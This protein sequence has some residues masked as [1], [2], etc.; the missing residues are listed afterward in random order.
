MKEN[1]AK[2]LYDTVEV[3]VNFPDSKIR[4]TLGGYEV[5]CKVSEEWQRVTIDSLKGAGVNPLGKSAGLCAYETVG[6]AY[7]YEQAI[8]KANEMA[9]KG[10]GDYV[11]YIVLK[12]QVQAKLDAWGGFDLSTCVSTSLTLP[13]GHNVSVVLGESI[14]TKKVPAPVATFLKLGIRGERSYRWMAYINNP[15][16]DG[17]YGTGSVKIGEK[18]AKET[19]DFIKRLED[20]RNRIIETS[21]KTMAELEKVTFTDSGYKSTITNAIQSTRETE[22]KTL[23]DAQL[24][25]L[26]KIDETINRV[27]KR[28]QG[29]HEQG[30]G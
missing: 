27:A 26:K 4:A 12:A 3:P 5:Y 17:G 21:D 7:E 8:N 11:D 25:T 13:C 10:N 29:T 19:Y 24:E 14:E 20:E 23:R 16:Q 2:I 1:F 18:K 30:G 28:P 6:R 22:L 15:N 9:E